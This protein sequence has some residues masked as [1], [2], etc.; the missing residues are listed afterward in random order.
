MALYT[1]PS[2]QSWLGHELE[3]RGIDAMIYTRYILSIL[4]QDNLDV[5]RELLQ[6]PGEN[7][8]QRPGKDIC[9]SGKGKN[10]KRPK[11]LDVEDFKKSTAVKCLQSVVEQECDIENLVEE[12]C[13]RLKS[14]HAEQSAGVSLVSSPRGLQ[15]SDSGSEYPESDPEKYYEAFPALSDKT[16][17]LPPDPKPRNSWASKVLSCKGKHDAEGNTCKADKRNTHSCSRK[18]KSASTSR[19]STTPTKYYM[20]H[21]RKYSLPENGMK[22]RKSTF[23]CPVECKNCENGTEIAANSEESSKKNST[24]HEVNAES[25]RNETLCDLLA[26][27]AKEDWKWYTDPM[28]DFFVPSTEKSKLETLYKPS[29]KDESPQV[30]ES[31]QTVFMESL[32]PEA[33]A[34]ETEDD[35]RM[36]R[37]NKQT[38]MES[39]SKACQKLIKD[40]LDELT[41][42]GEDDVCCTASE[43]TK[44]DETYL[45]TED[46]FL[47]CT[48]CLKMTKSDKQLEEHGCA[49]VVVENNNDK[50]KESLTVEDLFGAFNLAAIWDRSRD[51]VVTP[52]WELKVDTDIQSVEQDITAGDMAETTNEVKEMSQV[53]GKQFFL[54]QSTLD[55][56]N[57]INP[58]LQTAWSHHTTP[59]TSPNMDLN[60]QQ[61][62]TNVCE[63]QTHPWNL[64]HSTVLPE[65][66]E[67]N[68]FD[69]W[70]VNSA[71]W[72]TYDL[73]LSP[74]QSPMFVDYN[75]RASGIQSEFPSKET[76]FIPGGVYGDIEIKT[77]DCTK[78]DTNISPQDLWESDPIG[79][80][81]PPFSSRNSSRFSFAQADHDK[82]SK[83]YNFNQ[84]TTSRFRFAQESMSQNGKTYSSSLPISDTF[85]N[86]LKDKETQYNLQSTAEGVKYSQQEILS[87]EFVPDSNEHRHR[88][89]TFTYHKGAFTKIIP[90]TK[91]ET[92]ETGSSWSG[93]VR[94]VQEYGP[95]QLSDTSQSFSKQMV[96]WENLLISPK[97]HFKPIKESLSSDSPGEGYSSENS[98]RSSVKNNETNILDLHLENDDIYNGLGGR[99][100]HSA[101]DCGGSNKSDHRIKFF[102]SQYAHRW[103]IGSDD[104]EIAN[105]TAP[106]LNQTQDIAM[107]WPTN[108]KGFMKK[109][110]KETMKESKETY[111]EEGQPHST[112]DLSNDFMRKQIKETMKESKETYMEEGQPHS[113]NDLSNDFMKKQVT[114][115]M[116]EPTEVYM[117]GKQLHST[118]DVLKLDNFLRSD[119]LKMSKEIIP[120]QQGLSSSQS[121][122]VDKQCMIPD[123]YIPWTSISGDSEDHIF[124]FEGDVPLDTCHM[125][126]SSDLEKE[127]LRYTQPD[128]LSR[129][130]Q[131]VK[132]G[133]KK[134][135]TFYLEG[136][137]HRADCKFAHDLSNITCRFWEEGSCFKGK[138]CPFLHG[139]PSE[140]D[141]ASRRQDTASK[142]N[143]FSFDVQHF[144]ELP[145]STNDK[146]SSSNDSTPP[147]TLHRSTIFK[148]DINKKTSKSLSKK[149]SV[150]PVVSKHKKSLPIN[151]KYKK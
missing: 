11:S 93:P 48:E 43:L 131:S 125:P 109:Q 112:N 140:P 31:N 16:N 15:S 12:L 29:D 134:P 123:V 83:T 115:T 103:S 117:E 27:S 108:T 66:T 32:H 52:S 53:P 129:K 91:A 114:E 65:E 86:A 85:M 13:V 141:T 92:S 76:S 2:L 113:T 146:G 10:V 21:Q 39:E 105:Y 59:Y 20:K 49:S 38:A 143:A 94:R 145:K 41:N 25:A 22:L 14:L 68:N 121:Q 149:L 111:M 73:E 127:W 64:H 55:P 23:F 71:L 122:V 132:R 62:C 135:C 70:D 106:K 120:N 136:S 6:S 126:Y 138:D 69:L 90:Q 102:L 61:E 130:K 89:T 87:D 107:L 1:L 99:F 96:A 37:L 51:E 137:C 46:L 151:I 75:L 119:S 50:E 42:D 40:T 139:Y 24:C 150:Q 100:A 45:K 4:Q 60:K 58:G 133:W 74:I 63:N 101:P 35:T 128:T 79:Q 5:E 36:I 147:G 19:N 80:Q 3:V 8:L 142:S 124:P 84:R 26:S 30:D 98:Q 34:M 18:T 67:N 116:K 144:P 104:A 95:F 118:D 44:T 110:I 97:T 9:K 7:T 54:T 57:L 56:D 88:T 82:N 47:G 148:A 72:S 77:G 33:I 17:L 28:A 81:Y 78:T